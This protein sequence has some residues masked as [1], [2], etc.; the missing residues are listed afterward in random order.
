M[1]IFSDAR[2]AL[3]TLARNPGFA[4]VAILTLGLGIGMSVAVWSVVDAVLIEPLPYPD[5]DRLVEMGMTLEGVRTAL[6][7]DAAFDVLM[8]ERAIAHAD[9]QDLLAII[10][11][12]VGDT[13]GGAP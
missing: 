7:L 5:A 3:R 12:E 8:A 9:D 4:A 10:L 11:G 6:D 1:T 13:R 2:F